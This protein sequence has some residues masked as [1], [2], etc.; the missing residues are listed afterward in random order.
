M[1]N[2]LNTALNNAEERRRLQ[3]RLMH[4][5]RLAAVGEMAAGIAHELN[6]PLAAVANYAQACERL[7]AMPDCDLEEIRGAL[8]EITAQA[9]RAGDIIHR[10]RSLARGQ[11]ARRETTDVSALLGE[12]AELIEADASHHQTECR[13][14]LAQ[15]LPPVE[16]D[17]AQIQQVVLSLARNA[18][19]ALADTPAGSR[20]LLVKTTL[21]RSGDVEIAICDSGPGVSEHIAERL[22]DPFCTTK[23]SGTGLGLASSRTIARSHGG[24]LEYRPI[25]PSGACFVLSLP[26]GR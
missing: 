10:L 1:L 18:L 13:M 21:G 3:D 5:S 26:A 23:P 17:R 7:L 11:E 12:L 22:F 16:V 8:R 14:E 15:G 19:E 24:T 4:V 6:Q 9:V 2:S 25:T 20:T